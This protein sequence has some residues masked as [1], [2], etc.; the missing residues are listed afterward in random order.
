MTVVLA[1]F[2]GFSALRGR[3]ARTA[4]RANDQTSDNLRVLAETIRTESL[5]LAPIDT[6]FLRSTAF[7]RR[8]RVNV[9]EVGYAAA[10][11]LPVHEIPPSRAQHRPPTQWKFLEQPARQ[12]FEGVADLF[13][14]RDLLTEFRG[15][16]AEGF[17][18]GLL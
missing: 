17:Q 9:L 10:Y 15:A 13:R 11:A 14:Q 4:A 12:H 18:G 8:V 6:G 3:L 16:S 5:R 1:S 2:L 7:V